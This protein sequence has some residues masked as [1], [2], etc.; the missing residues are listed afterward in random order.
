MRA[1]PLREAHPVVPLADRHALSIGFTSVDVRA[2]F[3]LYRARGALPDV[4][5]LAAHIDE[6]IDELLALGAPVEPPVPARG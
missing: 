5:D 1:C 3:G 6:A 2:C 4:D